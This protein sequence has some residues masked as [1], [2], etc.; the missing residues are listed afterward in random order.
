MKTSEEL[1]H[2]VFS[3]KEKLRS[4]DAIL[5][6]SGCADFQN[7]LIENKDLKHQFL[8]FSSSLLFLEQMFMTD[9]EFDLKS[10]LDK[11]FQNCEEEKK[12]YVQAKVK[13]ELNFSDLAYVNKLES[14]VSITEEDFK[15]VE[16]LKKECDEFA[17][18]INIILNATDGRK[19]E[20]DLTTLITEQVELLRNLE[21]DLRIH[22]SQSAT[23]MKLN[24]LECC[25]NFC[26]TILAHQF[27]L[28]SKPVNIEGLSGVKIIASK[29]EHEILE[30]FYT[31]TFL[32]KSSVEVKIIFNLRNSSLGSSRGAIK[33]VVIRNCPMNVDDVIEQAIESNDYAFIPLFLQHQLSLT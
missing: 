18:K 19:S 6:F 29:P 20:N 21:K 4:Q 25:H 23:D 30:V 3:M 14:C 1:K 16:Q 27:F 28:N 31:N 7:A 5:N 10:D 12:N 33:E 15:H 11:A 17:E 9:K 13:N 24:E 8:A 26:D 32:K 22:I 2:V